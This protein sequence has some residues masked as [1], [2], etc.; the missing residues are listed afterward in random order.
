[1]DT[2]SRL[3]ES[4]LSRKQFLTQAAG[5]VAVGALAFTSGC[6]L[7]STADEDAG[8]VVEA[9]WPWP[10]EQ[11]D[12]EEIRKLGHLG[13]YQGA[14]CYGAFSAI[15]NSLKEKVGGPY[16]VFPVDMMRYGEGGMVGW[17]TLCG[18][19]NGAA[20]AITL[21]AGEDGYNSIV[22][23]LMGWYTQ[24]PFPSDQSNKYASKHAFLVDKYKS[25]EVLAQNISGSPLCHVSVT[26][27]CEK[28]GYASGSSERS[29][30]C[31]RLTGDAAAK[32]VELLNEY[33]STGK[34]I[35]AYTPNETTEGCRSCH[36]K[37]DDY[38]AGQFTRG[39]MECEPCHD[40]PH[41]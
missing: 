12:P 35:T 14:C 21:I 39:K 41:D 6:N 32:T 34:I 3:S 2:L 30:R 16:K 8:E 13:Y 24:S 10:Y 33:K 9:E 40:N 36:F 29:E 15:I 31:A 25:D 18:T 28:S 4:R 19:L 26:R 7:L 1:M 17:G 38:D 27:W 22:D 37:G 11:L 20:A 5:G 23:Q